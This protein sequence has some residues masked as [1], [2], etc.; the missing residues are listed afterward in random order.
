MV[1]ITHSQS[2][3]RALIWV[4]ALLAPFAWCAAV[5]LMFSLVDETC[6]QGSRLMLWVSVLSCIAVAVAPSVLIAPLRRSPDNSARL[7]RDLVVAGSIV[8]A[9][10]MLVTG[11]PVLMLDACRS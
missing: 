3:P 6:V 1:S 11:V 7:V 8:F 9:M 4:A 10:V 5:S 2:R